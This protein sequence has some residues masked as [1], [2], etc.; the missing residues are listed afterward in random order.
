MADSIEEARARMI[1]KRFGGNSKGASTGGGGTQRRKKKSAHKTSN[2]GIIYWYFSNMWSNLIFL[3]LDDKKIADT[4]K[5]LGCNT[6]PGIEEV[7]IFKDD[8]VIHFS[9]PKGML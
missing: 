8:E 6:I 4:L 3:G 7:N 9:A 1:A 5:K 2:A